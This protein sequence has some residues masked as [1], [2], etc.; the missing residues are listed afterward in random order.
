MKQMTCDINICIN[1]TASAFNKCY[2]LFVVPMSPLYC[3]LHD[4]KYSA[5]TGHA[6]FSVLVTICLQCSFKLFREREILHTC[7]N[8][9]L[10]GWGWLPFW[11]ILI[12]FKYKD[13]GKRSNFILKYMKIFFTR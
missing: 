4:L 8:C 9:T 13:N 6:Q 10:R 7:A 3:C 5:T 12:S 1:K 2:W 11:T